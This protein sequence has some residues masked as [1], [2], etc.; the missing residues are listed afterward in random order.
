MMEGPL[1]GPFFFPMS[2]SDRQT[3]T[4]VQW[5]DAKGYGFIAPDG[6]AARLFVHIQAFAVRAQ[7][8][9]PGE[10]LSFEPGRDAQGKPRAL[11]VRAIK[12]PPAPAPR[13]DGGRVLLLIPAFASLVLACHLA[14]GLPHWLWGLYS[15][16]SMATFIVYALDK[17][18]ARRGDWR[19]GENSL[20]ALSLACGWPGALLAQRLLRHKSVKPAFRRVYWLT[21]V[22]NVAAFVALFTPLLKS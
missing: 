7:R 21:V 6:G 22:V 4:L 10:R 13:R 14:W 8:P 16:M 20:H 3:G 18:A 5:D 19:V 12:S 15:S 2:S 17:R 11:D 1:A 9:V